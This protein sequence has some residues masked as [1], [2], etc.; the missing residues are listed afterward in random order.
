MMAFTNSNFNVGRLSKF[1]NQM[2]SLLY[3]DRELSKMISIKNID[4]KEG[5][6]AATRPTPK[7]EII[8]RKVLLLLE[9]SGHGIPWIG[10]T[11]F[12]IYYRRDIKSTQFFCNL[13]LALLFDLLI[14]G[15]LKV[16]VRRPRPV[17]NVDDMFATVSVDRYSFPSGHSTRA[18]MVAFLFSLYWTNT[19]HVVLGFVWASMVA[20]SRVV[21]G[22]HHVSDVTLGVTIGYLQYRFILKV[23]LTKETCMILMGF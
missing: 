5:K 2:E 23:W 4:N 9:Y 7:R 10:V 14:V 20:I 19:A 1:K 13:F 3:Y 15:L 18:A 12:K 17:Y 21:L 11:L 22:R 16:I 6:D 8:L